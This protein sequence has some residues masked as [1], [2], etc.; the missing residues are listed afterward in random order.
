[1]FVPIQKLLPGV[2]STKL[3]RVLHVLMDMVPSGAVENVPGIKTNASKLLSYLKL[4]LFLKDL[5]IIKVFVLKAMDT[6]K[7]MG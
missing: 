4:I 5:S 6:I 7:M 1:M 2:A 3:L